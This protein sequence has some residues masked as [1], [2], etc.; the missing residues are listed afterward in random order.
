M[1]DTKKISFILAAVLGA[2]VLVAASV[3]ATIVF[4]P[5]ETVQQAEGGE[6]SG[7]GDTAADG[8][9]KSS[10][11]AHY[12]AVEIPPVN[13]GPDDPKRFLQLE[14]QLMTH[15]EKVKSAVEKHMPAVRNGLILLLSEQSSKKLA[16]RQGK[17]GLR[18]SMRKRI[19]SVLDDKN[20]KASIKEIYLTRMVMQ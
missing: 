5:S 1:A 19:E 20:A 9:D 18:E 15:D 17:Q 7:N 2:I 6:E 14:F 10:G 3:A 8:A 16:T 11:E 4:F 12:L 13:F